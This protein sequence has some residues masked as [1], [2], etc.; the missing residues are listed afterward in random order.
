MPRSPKARTWGAGR[1]RFFD[2]NDRHTPEGRGNPESIDQ[3]LIGR[4]TGHLLCQYPISPVCASIS[5][6]NDV[7]RAIG[8]Y[9]I[10]RLSAEGVLTLRASVR[11]HKKVYAVIA[12]IALLAALAEAWSAAASMRGRMAARFDI[13]HGHNI[14]LAYGLPPAWRSEYDR[15]LKERYGIEVRTVAF[16]IV[17]EDLRSYADSYDEVSAAA[18]NQKFEHDVF[19]ECAEAASAR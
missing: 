14:V 9:G 3:V 13:R 6:A 16:C 7:A 5:E 10:A 1:Y 18:A 2:T 4:I 8:S 11:K 12:S 19:K 15:L 17:S